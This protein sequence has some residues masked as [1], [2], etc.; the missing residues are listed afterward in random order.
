MV[1]KSDSS[2]Y[3][4]LWIY[5]DSQARRMYNEVINTTLC[6]S[7]FKSCKVSTNWVYTYR[8]EQPSQDDLDF[9]H[10]KITKDIKNVLERPEMSDNS[11]MVLNLGL[12]F[13]HSTN[14]SNYVKLLRGVV[15]LFEGKRQSVRMIWKTST[16]LSKEKDIKEAIYS[17]R[18]RFLNNPVIILILVLNRN[19]PKCVGNC[20]LILHM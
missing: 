2:S 14:F 3:N 18:K 9:D 12:H 17:D 15:G 5:G 20:S 11:V 4:T 10:K 1:N 8:E 16:S 13:L 19:F 6:R 7:I